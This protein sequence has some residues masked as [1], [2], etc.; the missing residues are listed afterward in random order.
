MPVV[1]T[2]N[3]LIGI[4]TADDVADVIEEEATE[5]MQKMFGAGARKDCSAPGTSAS[6][7]A[8]LA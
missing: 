4:I 8:S 5:D 3:R 7:S 6:A 1:N 2:R